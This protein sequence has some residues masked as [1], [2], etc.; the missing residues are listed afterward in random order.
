MTITFEPGSHSRADRPTH[1]TYDEL[2]R[3]YDHFNERLFG[4]GLPACLITLQRE[5]RTCGYFSAQRWASMDGR[6]TDEIAMNPAY[7]AVTPIVETMQTLVHEMVHLWQYHFGKPGRGRYHNGEWANK[8]EAIGL[9]PSSTGKPGGARTGDHMADYAIEGGPFLAACEELLTQSFQISWY[10]RFP[11]ADHI[12]HGLASQ[13]AQLSNSAAAALP[14]QISSSLAS[15]VRGASTA[16]GQVSGEETTTGPQP[17]PP[18]AANR[19]NRVK[20]SCS[21]CGVNVWGKPGLNVVC[22]D[23]KVPFEV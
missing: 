20:Y 2:Q 6:T 14:I 3:A 9:M 22:G 8:M 16:I 7:F 5:K 1:V 18:A 19:S 13:A 12:A 10:D 15:M 11:A 17:A 4:N 21:G 23:C